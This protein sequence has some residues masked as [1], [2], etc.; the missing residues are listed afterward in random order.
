MHVTV[1]ASDELRRTRRLAPGEVELAPLASHTWVAPA[2]DRTD[3]APDR[4][5]CVRVLA[6][7]SPRPLH[8]SLDGGSSPVEHLPGRLAAIL[9]SAGDPEM[10]ALDGEWALAW[11]D[12][13]VR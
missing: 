2:L 6:I 5:M 11:V 10:V 8:L 4:P 3:F 7:A 9:A 12:L 1:L 13:L